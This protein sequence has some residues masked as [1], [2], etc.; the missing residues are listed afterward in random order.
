ML[1]SRIQKN[2]TIKT[3]QRL[4]TN[5]INPED[6]KLLRKKKTDMESIKGTKIEV[7]EKIIES[8]FKNKQHQHVKLEQMTQLS[9]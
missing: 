9:L 2:P 4:K 1:N 8:C 7:G 5:E 3:H 6:R